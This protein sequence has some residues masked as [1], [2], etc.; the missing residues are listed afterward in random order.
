MARPKEPGK[1]RVNLI[2]DSAAIDAATAAARAQGMD[3]STYVR[4]AVYARLK[5]EGVDVVPVQLKAGRPKAAKGD[6]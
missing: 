1:T 6:E 2:M 5:R 4:G 3:F